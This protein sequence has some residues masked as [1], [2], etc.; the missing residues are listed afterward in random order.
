MPYIYIYTYYT[1][2]IQIRRSLWHLKQRARPLPSLA[3]SPRGALRRRPPAAAGSR[4]CVVAQRDRVDMWYMNVYTL[5]HVCLSIYLSICLSICLS[6]FPSICLSIYMSV[7]LS[8]YLSI[9]LCVC[10]SI[11]LSTY[12]SIYLSIYLSM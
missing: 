3:T 9:Y 6:V 7:Y 10:L 12:L 2:F 11:C 1:I 4:G 8:I 5:T